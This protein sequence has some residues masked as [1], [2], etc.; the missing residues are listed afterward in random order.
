MLLLLTSNL[1]YN[2]PPTLNAEAVEL[3]VD[4]PSVLYVTFPDKLSLT[5]TGFP[6]NGARSAAETTVTKTNVN[7][8]SVVATKS[9]F[10]DFLLSF[11]FHHCYFFTRVY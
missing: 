1:E 3:H 5:V 9:S 10:S 11:I 4:P 6:L 2:E 7:I 8:V